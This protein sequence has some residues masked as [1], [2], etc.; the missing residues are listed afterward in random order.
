[1]R[2]QQRVSVDRFDKMSIYSSGKNRKLSGHPNFQKC[3]S[4]SKWS[5][6]HSNQHLQPFSQALL[7]VCLVFTV[8]HTS[9][10]RMIYIH[11]QVMFEQKKA[12]FNAFSKYHKSIRRHYFFFLFF[13]FFVSSLLTSLVFLSKS[14]LKSGFFFL[15]CFS[16]SLSGALR[17]VSALFAEAGSGIV[18]QGT[19]IGA[20]GPGHSGGEGVST[21]LVVRAQAGSCEGSGGRYGSGR[22]GLA[23]VEIHH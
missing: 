8:I 5:T 4:Q 18:E 1:M 3:P 11:N 14:V 12:R 22:N 6:T 23:L 19:F 16:E 20:G 10:L 17:L 13:S 7:Y 15:V 9:T 21:R 2:K